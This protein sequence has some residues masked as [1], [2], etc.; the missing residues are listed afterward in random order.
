LK[1]F[2][3]LCTDLEDDLRSNNINYVK[4]SPDRLQGET[5]ESKALELITLLERYVISLDYLV[6][7]V[8]RA[9]PGII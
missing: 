1:E 3:A 7:A 2:T 6:A 5:I 8:R 4:I 9:R